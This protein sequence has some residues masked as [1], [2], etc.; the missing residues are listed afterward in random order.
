[1]AEEFVLEIQYLFVADVDTVILTSGYKV[2]ATESYL[3][4]LALDQTILSILF[5]T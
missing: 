4:R 1:L 5:I 3:V 2:V